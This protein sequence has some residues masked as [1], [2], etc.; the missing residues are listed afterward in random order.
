MNLK[1]LKAYIN[2]LELDV[3]GNDYKS[4]Q[5]E[6]PP[7]E[8]AAPADEEKKFVNDKSLVSFAAGVSGENQSDLLDSL[9]LSQ[10][11]ANK[12]Y[13]AEDEPEQW[14]N[15][16]SGVMNNIGWIL[17]E[18]DFSTYKAKGNI[19]EIESVVMDVLE[20]A[21]GAKII[22]I[23]KSLLNAVKGLTEKDSTKFIAFE[24]NTHSLKKGNFLL[25]VADET[26]A[27]LS[28]SMCMIMIEST[29]QIKQILFFK[30]TKDDTK[31]DYSSVNGTLNSLK[32]AAVRSVVDKKL[33]DYRNDYIANIDI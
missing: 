11:A 1:F 3:P 28:F 23:A 17:E 19:I 5:D 10:L 2:D 29:H 33:E 12:Q 27:T 4:L 15:A 20:S 6:V 31:V 26:N 16:F 13:S 14:F 8:K 24:K 22:P 18:S 25:G 32:F 7:T 21:L 30:S 9:L